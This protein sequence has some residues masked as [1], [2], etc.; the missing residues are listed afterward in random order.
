P[1]YQLA[2]FMLCDYGGSPMASIYTDKR[3]ILLNVPDAEQDALTGSKS[4]DI[5]L[6]KHI[7]NVDAKDKAIAGLL[8]DEAVWEQQAAARFALRRY[9]FAPYHGYSA[10]V[11]ADTLRHL[12]YILPSGEAA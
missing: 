3:L 6:R 10:Q 5:L 2:D 1:L 12:Q 8:P 7:T 4:P 11:A 9:Y